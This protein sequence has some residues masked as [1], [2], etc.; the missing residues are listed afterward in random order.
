[1]AQARDRASFVP[2]PPPKDVRELVKR[3]VKGLFEHHAFDHAAAM[4]FYFFLG[5]I[6]LLVVVG[7][8]L[9]RAVNEQGAEHLAGPLFELM[10]N[11]AAE[12]LRRELHS[13]AE[14]SSGTIAPLSLAG[15]LILTSNGVHNLMDVFELVAHAPPRRWLKQRIIA[16]AWVL[17]VA[18][19]IL[20]AGFGVYWIDT[21]VSRAPVEGARGLHVLLD[22][23]RRFLA[24][25]WR[26]MG[27][28]VLLV[29]L[30]AGGLATFYR[31]G[32]SHP[33]EV[34][35]RVWPGTLVALVVWLVV[36]TAFG[37]YVRALGAYA[38][39]YGSLATVATFLVWLYLT[40]LA[41]MIG[42]EVNVQL[43][44][45]RMSASGYAAV[46]PLA[47]P[48]VPAGRTDS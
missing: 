48:Q 46:P 15:F 33:R 24:D 31:T 27:I 1:M 26:L 8:L 30:V 10:P 40:S 2:A 28:A 9:G 29:L 44:G 38:V 6:P 19:V 34:R 32:I 16:I 3:V 45:S 21:V 7:L 12:F 11:T 23:G 35:R 5:M 4:S 42:A 47:P 22:R 37:E 43:E 17:G 36:S 13:I 25:G 20:G 14:T 39:Y 18:I 41:F